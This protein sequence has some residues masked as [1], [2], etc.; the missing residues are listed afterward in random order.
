MAHQLV[1]A[2][3]LV[4][5]EVVYLTHG[6]AWSERLQDAAIDDDQTRQAQLL[7]LGEAAERMLDVVA[8][9]LMPVE[10]RDARNDATH[11]ETL[12]RE[13]GR[14]KVPCLRIEEAGGARWLYESDAIVAYLH[15]QFDEQADGAA[16]E[17]AR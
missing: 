14:W 1:T 2:N 7:A 17:V 9:Y 12:A 16:P 11:R 6:G 13:G 8:A 10:L 4:D 15:E 5:G 3:R